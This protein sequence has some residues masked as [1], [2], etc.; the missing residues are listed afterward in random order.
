[1]SRRRYSHP[2]APSWPTVDDMITNEPQTCDVC[3]E[4]IPDGRAVYHRG[5]LTGPCCPAE[6]PHP[7][8]PPA[9]VR[10]PY[11]PGEDDHRSAR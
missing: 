3:R 7:A 1:M 4:A 5:I 9:L 2:L 6:A 10:E 11:E 8:D